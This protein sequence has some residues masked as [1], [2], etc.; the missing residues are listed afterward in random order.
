M[1][2][3]WTTR[4]DAKIARLG[5]KAS[6]AVGT[7]SASRQSAI[8]RLRSSARLNTPTRRPEMAM[9]SVLALAAS[10]ISDGF[11]A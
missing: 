7:D 4:S 11:T 1:N 8:A 6:A 3:P 9:P 10:P 2:R 5:A